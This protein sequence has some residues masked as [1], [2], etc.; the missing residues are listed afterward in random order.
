ML[1]LTFG[2]D[3]TASRVVGKPFRRKNGKAS[4]VLQLEAVGMRKLESG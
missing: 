1:L 2:T 3:S 4:G